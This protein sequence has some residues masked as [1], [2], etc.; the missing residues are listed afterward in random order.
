VITYC[1]LHDWEIGPLWRYDVPEVGHGEAPPINPA[2]GK[3]FKESIKITQRLKALIK[4]INAPYLIEKRLKGL[5]GQSTAFTN[6]N[7]TVIDKPRL[8][9]GAIV[10]GEERDG[11]VWIEAI[12]A[13][14]P[15][16]SVEY[17]LKHPWLLFR[18]YIVKEGNRVIDFPYCTGADKIVH[19]VWWPVI[20]NGGHILVSTQPHPG[21]PYIALERA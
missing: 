17:V 7:P 8:G 4:G 10:H 3:R 6:T 18:C 19:P 13:L 15:L 12:D 14:K 20:A 21:K 16:P 1:V 5:L 9:G 2:T 11:V